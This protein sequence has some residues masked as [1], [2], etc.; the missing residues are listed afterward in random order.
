MLKIIFALSLVFSLSG[1]GGGTTP[2]NTPVTT[3]NPPTSILTTISGVVFAGAHY[4]SGL[5][6]IYNFT[7]GVKG[8]LLASGGVDSTGAYQLK[9]SNIPSAILVEANNGCYV[10]N[11]LPW[12][13]AG[14]GVGYAVNN[15][16]VTV[17]A[18]PIVLSAAIPVTSGTTPLVVSVTPF[19]N[20]AF[21]LAQFYKRTNVYTSVAS[22]LTNANLVVSQWVGVDII[23]TLPSEPTRNTALADGAI[24]GVLLSG[25]PTW[26][27]NFPGVGGGSGGEGFGTT[28]TSLAFA[29]AMRSDLAEDGV[30]NGIGRDSG[31]NSVSLLI[32]TVAMTTAVYRHELA[33]T[34]TMR[35]RSETEGAANPFATPTEKSRVID[36]LPALVAFNG[37]TSIFDNSAVLA[38]DNNFSIYYTYPSAGLVLSNNNGVSGSVVADVVGVLYENVALYIDGIF[39]TNFPGNHYAFSHFINTTVFANGPHTLTVTATNNL[40]TV[41][42]VSVNVTFSN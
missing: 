2:V 35:F 18:S 7:S 38:L 3:P 29:D 39:Y 40:G 23:K 9:V 5:V 14:A 30:L 28:Y 16:I 13:V 4:S 17:C 22:A 37:K 21:G 27:Y 11:G 33:Q 8:V 42:S 32:G 15:L 25:I 20:A 1:C 36:F 26:I 24:Y 34:A 6:S 19:T 41:R 10:E 12:N 31:G